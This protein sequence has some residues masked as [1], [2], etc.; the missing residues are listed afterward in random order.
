MS[1]QAAELGTCCI[2]LHS[3][4]PWVA[5]AGAW[6][7][8]EE[9]LYQ[10]WA[11][12]YLPVIDVLGRLADD[13]RTDVLTL[14][15]TPVLAGMLDDPYCLREF[16]T[17]VA[18]WLVRAEGAVVDG[19]P[20]AR[21]EA[22]LAAAALGEV[23][24]RWAA[25]ASPLL[26]DLAGAG[27][28][29]LLGGPASHPFTPLLDERIA[30]CQLGVGLDDALL[31]TGARPSGIWAPECAFRPGL[32]RLY[33]SARVTH[34][35]IDGPTVGGDTGRAYDVAGS[36][37]VAFPRDLD[38]TYRVWSPRAG[39][40]GGPWYR[41][42]HTFDHPSGLKP[43]RVT[44]KDSV[45]KQPYD[46]DAA[47]SAVRTDVADFVSTVRRRLLDLRTARDGRPGL[48]VVAYDTELFGHWWHEGPAF[49]DAVLRLLP[50]AG[51]R[52]TTLA[53]ALDDHVE[54]ARELPCGSWGLGK[55]W[56]VWTD[57]RDLVELAAAV[58]ER[59]LQVVDKRVDPYARRD[60]LDQLTRE[61]F[62][63]LASDW[64]FSV[65][66]DNAA[67]YARGRA[68]GHAARF[69]KLAEALEAYDDDEADALAA[70]FRSLTY[71]FAHLDA[72]GLL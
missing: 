65:S 8:G 23:G 18:D 33:A 53:R 42:F 62:L 63:V 66:H 28:I 47:L 56:H 11:G 13:G 59:L 60:A 57:P 19:V 27:V 15:M 44:S 20:A 30:R 14:G 34:F 51:V 54:G 21:R 36:G 70:D 64:A 55:D 71:P 17:W 61:A 29:E 41:D 72:R 35:V 4:L 68:Q 32:E 24:G 6:P 50:E 40:P 10:A 58:S 31:R 9:W 39:Y 25:G 48:V 26:R 69:F 52:V 49:L 12:A 67:Q 22:R 38:V 7:V 2:V 45:Y 43:Y 46:P 16:R 37:V 1:R 3:H 5:H